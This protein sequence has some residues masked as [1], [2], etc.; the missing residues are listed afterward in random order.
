[1]AMRISFMMRMHPAENGE[2][3]LLALG[4]PSPNRS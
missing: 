1:M 4:Q 3:R 2:A